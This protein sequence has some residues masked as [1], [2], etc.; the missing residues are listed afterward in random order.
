MRIVQERQNEKALSLDLIAAGRIVAEACTFERKLNHDGYA[1]GEIIEACLSTDEAIPAVQRLLPRI[2]EARANFNLDFIGENR[3]LSA[4][5]TAQPVIALN[6]LFAPEQQD[7]RSGMRGFFA[8]DDLLGSP[9]DCVP[10]TTLLAWCDEVS[11]VRYPLI[12]ASMVPFTK[13]RNSDKP[14]WK[15]VALA[16]LDRA[17]N[18]VEVMKHYIDHFVPMTWSGSRVAIWEANVQL[19]DEFEAHPDVE[20]AAFARFRRS[21]LERVLNDERRK[22]LASERRH[23]E[24]FE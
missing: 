21:E 12:A 18:R 17:P 6:D 20:L 11:T 23:N 4:I 15:S 9:L 13:P 3:I 2:R 10:E 24:T 1:L 14:Q 22:E 5:F 8:H 19:L 7:E 16:L